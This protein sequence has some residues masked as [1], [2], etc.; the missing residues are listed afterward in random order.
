MYEYISY[1]VY[2]GYSCKGF[3]SATRFAFVFIFG[4]V[5]VKDTFMCVYKYIGLHSIYSIS[6]DIIYIDIYTF[7]VSALRALFW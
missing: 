6:I 5:K 1:K 4:G 7:I 3:I 2:F